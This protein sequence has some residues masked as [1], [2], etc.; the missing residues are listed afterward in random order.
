M[1]KG[2]PEQ[3]AQRREEIINA[4]EQLYQ[5]TSFRERGSTTVGT[6]S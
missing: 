6:S 2:T 1:R 5:T 3:I 4:C